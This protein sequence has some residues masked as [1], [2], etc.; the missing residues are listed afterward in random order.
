MDFQYKFTRS[1][2]DMV[3]VKAVA[4]AEQF[5]RLRTRL[6]AETAGH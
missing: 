6:T 2:W 1:T 5:P 3:E 4:G